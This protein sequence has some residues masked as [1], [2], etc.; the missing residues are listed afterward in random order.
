[1]KDQE[2]TNWGRSLFIAFIILVILGFANMAYQKHKMNK[3][4]DTY[5]IRR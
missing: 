3:M 1:M 2:E 5:G 4:L